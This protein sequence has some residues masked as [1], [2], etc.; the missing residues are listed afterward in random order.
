MHTE[1]SNRYC[2]VDILPYKA[3]IALGR[4][5]KITPHFVTLTH[6]AIFFPKPS[7]SFVF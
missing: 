5:K 3:N 6:V 7:N 1:K 2:G 4:E